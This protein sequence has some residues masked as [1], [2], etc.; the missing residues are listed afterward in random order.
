[1]RWVKHYK[2]G[3]AVYRPQRWS[4]CVVKLFT[5]FIVT[6]IAF[7]RLDSYLFVGICLAASALVLFIAMKPAA[8]Y[9]NCRKGLV[10][11]EFFRRYPISDLEI[12]DRAAYIRHLRIDL[13]HLSDEEMTH[14][15]EQIPNN[16]MPSDPRISGRRSVPASGA[17]L[18]FLKRLFRPKPYSMIEYQ[19]E[20]PTPESIYVNHFIIRAIERKE[21]IEISRSNLTSIPEYDID[22][23]RINFDNIVARCKELISHRNPL[24]VVTH[25]EQQQED[26]IQFEI[27]EDHVHISVIT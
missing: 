21:T 8:F 11:D 7:N 24:P 14:V 16:S 15:K 6:T 12:I 17:A 22:S 27:D 13:S 18:T 26:L 1:M 19:P 10:I 25:K 5:L 4:D 23:A 2:R 20:T 9:M 3:V